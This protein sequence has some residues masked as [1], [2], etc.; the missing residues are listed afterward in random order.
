M[1]YAMVCTMN[2]CMYHVIC[3]RMKMNVRMN[4]A[5]CLYWH[6]LAKTMCPDFVTC[7]NC[8][9]C[10]WKWALALTLLNMIAWKCWPHISIF[11]YT[12][13]RSPLLLLASPCYYP[14]AGQHRIAV[15]WSLSLTYAKSCMGL[16]WD[17]TFNRTL[18]VAGDPAKPK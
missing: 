10:N 9:N 2:V 5:C 18:S 6:E 13:S 11:S 1:Q 3:L 17:R 15:I 14:L 16:H 12:S 4:H 8:L 7:L